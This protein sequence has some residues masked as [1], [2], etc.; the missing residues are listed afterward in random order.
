MTME[1]SVKELKEV[2]LLAVRIT[3][4]VQLALKDDG[5][6]GLSDAGILFSLLQPTVEAVAGIGELPAEI[7]DFQSEEAVE[8]LAMVSAEL[9]VDNE[10]AKKIVVAA[11]DMLATSTPK[12]A[13]LVQAIRA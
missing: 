5:K 1:K 8:L 12:V 11:L 4:G 3:N 10:K 13:A 9:A 6:I 7:A 2:L